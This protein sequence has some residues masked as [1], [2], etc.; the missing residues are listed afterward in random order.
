MRKSGFWLAALLLIGLMAG[1]VLASD[2]YREV[3]KNEYWVSWN[4][5]AN[6][7]L[8]TTVYSPE[9]LLNKTRESIAQMGIENATKAFVSQMAQRLSQEG[10]YLRNATGEILG[11]NS[12]GPLTT[13][14][15]GQI[16]NFARYYSYG[17]VWEISLDVLRVADLAQIDPTK[18]NGS[19][20]LENYFIVHLPEGAKI[21]KLPS[22]YSAQSNG[23]Y[24][25]IDVRRNGTT[26]YVHSIVYFA[27]GV[28]YSDIQAI[29]GQPR[30]F[31]IQYEGKPGVENY[32]T[33]QMNIYN[34]ITV[35]KNQ[36]V[37]DSVE[38]Y[39]KPESYINYLKFQITY[40][41]VQRAEQ[42]LYQ[43]YVQEFQAQGIGVRGGSVRILNLN[44]TGP[45]VVKYHF[46]LTNFTRKVNGTYVYAYDPKLELGNMEFLNR[47]DA[48]INETKVT[49]FVLP[50]GA[51][52]TELPKNINIEL[53]G[54][55]IVMTVEK[56]SDR[57]VVVKSNVF[58]RY[59]TPVD[60]YRALMAKV[61]SKV[62][63]KYTLTEG[64]SS[65][66]ICGPALI[67]GL[68]VIPLLLRRR[69]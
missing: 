62:E 4:G 15:R 24:I 3:Q 27:K 66:S 9:S 40:Q 1:S 68:A 64:G 16:P 28:T 47:L 23:S 61:P 5:T 55:R 8:I 44:S 34:N 19:M 52:F 14:I 26:V 56:V 30:A 59:G 63:F 36:T 49:K 38:E 6:V 58:L 42:G 45:L 46:I 13:I 32:T 60:A 48:T 65:R 31:I 10:F 41:G 17:N 57:E 33:W 7:T 18:M 22:N 67:V 29:Y 25:R 21:T 37:F 50:E 2:N 53:N 11:Y 43:K 35:Q 54:S 20:T 39:L 69:L 12:T 51:K